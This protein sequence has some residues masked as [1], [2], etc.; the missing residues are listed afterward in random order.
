MQTKE[1]FIGRH[2]GIRC[3]ALL[4]TLKHRQFGLETNRHCKTNVHLLMKEKITNL[5]HLQVDPS[6]SYTWQSPGNY[7]YATIPVGYPGTPRS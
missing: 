2:F 3:I 7:G 1:Q 4:T 5:T 6:H